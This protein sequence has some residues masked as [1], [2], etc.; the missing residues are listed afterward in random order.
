MNYNRYKV[1]QIITTN[2]EPVE[3][4]ELAPLAKT[5]GDPTALPD[6]EFYVQ[7]GG[8]DIVILIDD[9]PELK[10]GDNNEKIDEY[11]N[12][13]EDH[14]DALIGCDDAALLL[15]EAVDNN[16]SAILETVCSIGSRPSIESYSGYVSVTAYGYNTAISTSDIET[17]FKHMAALT[18]NK[19][20]DGIV[21]AINGSFSILDNLIGGITDGALQDTVRRK[22][23]IALLNDMADGV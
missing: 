19:N 8:D 15:V 18:A 3:L 1:T 9:L 22:L 7:D 21:D 5:F 16:V 4:G 20:A 17:T 10:R 23:A 13:Y 6:S 14:G 12:A 2:E 11:K